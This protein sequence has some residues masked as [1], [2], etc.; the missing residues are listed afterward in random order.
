MNTGITQCAHC[1]GAIM[2][3]TF[4]VPGT[5]GD[6]EED[7]SHEWWHM[8]VKGSV[9]GGNQAR[10]FCAGTTTPAEPVAT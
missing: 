8:P 1:G 6:R 10:K 5:A 2:K 4:K 9:W 7:Y 3:F